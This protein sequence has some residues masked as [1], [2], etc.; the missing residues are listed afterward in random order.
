MFSLQDL[1][2][3]QQ[4]NDALGQISQAVG[5]DQ[6]A[7]SSAI[8]MA[9]PM[10][11]SG[12]AQKA[13]QPQT[14]PVITSA[15][16]QEPGGILDNLGGLLGGVNPMM[17]AGIL[18]TI[19]GNQQTQV[20]QEIGR[21]SG[22]NTG[23][24]ASILMML[25]PLVLGYFGRQ[26]SQQGLDQGGIIDMLGGHQRQIEQ[27]SPQSGWLSGMLDSNRN[28]SSMDELTAMAMQYFN[29]P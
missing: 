13:Q 2:G 11:V 28:G 6:S 8:N 3:Q 25:A 16:T 4:G 14:A 9:L 26:Q 21:Q 7:V 15:I 23:Q 5:A 27:Q 24:V 17:S 20:A 22:L 18:G 1:L 19:F 10:I 29:R 12:L